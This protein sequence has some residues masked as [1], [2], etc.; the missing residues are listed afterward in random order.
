M[1]DIYKLCIATFFFFYVRTNRNCQ[2]TSGR[3]SI[4]T[5]LTHPH[6]LAGCRCGSPDTDEQRADQAPCASQTLRRPLHAAGHASPRARA[7]RPHVPSGTLTRISTAREK[8]NKPCSKSNNHI[9][10]SY[11]RL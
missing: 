6:L 2:Q 7:L 8:Q 9:Y 10:L 5:V 4:I 3:L 11:E 1:H